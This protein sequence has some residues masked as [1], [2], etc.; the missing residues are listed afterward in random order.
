MALNLFDANAFYLATLQYL[1]SRTDEADLR[2]KIT[3]AV[4]VKNA[5]DSQVGLDTK[6]DREIPAFAADRTEGPHYLE[7]DDNEVPGV[8]GC[9][10]SN[11]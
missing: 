10:P 4:G 2:T 5:I 3:Q 1:T 8:Y 6:C 11:P 7:L 9:T